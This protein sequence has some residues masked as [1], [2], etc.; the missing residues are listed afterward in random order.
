MSKYSGYV[1]LSVD[2]IVVVVRNAILNETITGSLEDEHITWVG[3]KK[4]Y[5]QVF[6]KYS[7]A[8]GNRMSL[9]INYYEQD[10]CTEVMAIATGA[11]QGA[12]LKLNFF[13]ENWLISDFINIIEPYI[14]NKP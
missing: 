10:G 7:M 5:T 12:F 2:E 13:S 1:K 4:V 6:E 14:I 3:G 9:T 11:S 8:G